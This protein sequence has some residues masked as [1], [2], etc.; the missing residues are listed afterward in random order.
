MPRFQKRPVVIEAY[1]T[2]E[3]VE[4]PTLEGLMIAEPGDWIITG[5]AGEKYPCKHEIF[6]QTYW[7]ADR[8]ADD[9]WFLKV[10]EPELEK[11]H[12]QP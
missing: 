5:V 12:A 4:I 6:A 1:R 2:G 10:S 8:D 7:P 9:Y 3:R 11:A